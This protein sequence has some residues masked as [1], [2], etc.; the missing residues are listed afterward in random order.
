M[1]FGGGDDGPPTNPAP[2]KLDQSHTAVS[3]AAT[4]IDPKAPRN[5]DPEPVPEPGVPLTSTTLNVNGM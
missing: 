4:P 1:C 3:R 5:E 2:Y